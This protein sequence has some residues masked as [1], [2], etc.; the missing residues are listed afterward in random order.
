MNKLL[1]LCL[2]FCLSHLDIKAQEITMFTGFFDNQYYQDD[3]KIN[4]KE[5]TALLEKDVVAFNHWE[6]AK[7]FNTLAQI[8]LATEIGFFVWEIADTNNTKNDTAIKIGVSGSLAAVIVF[9]ILSHSQK[10]NAILKYN[11]GLDN[12]NAFS[13][14]PSKNGLG[15][16]MQF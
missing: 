1:P 15:V 9:S 4:K 5:L 14:K 8:A 3:K 7:T 6:K 16:V 13:I 12:S 10:K 2:I 11:Q